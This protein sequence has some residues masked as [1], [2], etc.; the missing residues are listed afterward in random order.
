MK[1]SVSITFVGSGNLAWHLAPAFDNTDF[2]VREVFSQNKKNAAELVSKLY[3]AEAKESLDFSESPSK[4]F[5]LA[6]P[7]DVIEEIATQ[8]ILPDESILIHASGSKP[9]SILRDSST[10]NIGVL[11]PLQTF[12]KG[13][14]IDVKEVPFFVEGENKETEKILLDMATAIGAKVHLLSSDKRS[15]LHLSAVFAS[16]FTNHMLSIAETIMVQN[17]MDYDWLKPLI[18]E[19]INKSLAIGPSKAQTGPARREDL[20]ILDQHMEYLKKDESLQEIYR[21]ISQHIL[22]KYQS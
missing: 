5:I 3:Q 22:D 20:E 4:I 11:Y 8:I 16:N 17:K 6:I 14:K 1:N 10:S 19:T 9:L 15:M 18:A 7:D 21:V 12:T 2:A 13:K